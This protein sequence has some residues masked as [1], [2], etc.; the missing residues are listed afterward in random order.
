[1]IIF[2][3]VGHKSWIYFFYASEKVTTPY[4]GYNKCFYN[5]RVDIGF[6][7]NINTPKKC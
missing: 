2:Y 3:T 7:H 4:F 5:G 6:Y 1:M